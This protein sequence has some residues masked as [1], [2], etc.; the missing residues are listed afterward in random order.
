MLPTEHGSSLHSVGPKQTRVSLLEHLA[1]GDAAAW[2]EVDS[3]YRPMIAAWLSRF[4]LQPSDAEDLSQEV[5]SVLFKR[6][7]TFEH[8]GRTGAFRTWLRTITCNQA[9]SFL[10]SRARRPVAGSA[11][12]AEV[13]DR[14]QQPDSDVAR[15]FDLE[16]DRH[17][18]GYLLKLISPEIAETTMAAFQRHVIDGRDAETVGHELGISPTT[19]IVAKSRVLR[20]LRERAT[21]LVGETALGRTGEADV[22]SGP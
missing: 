5:M 18:L 12:L 6:L 16:H 9:R 13:V 11:R 3:I 21:M 10:R 15:S 8:N 17:L 4:D 19:V 14:L 7:S 22:E 1:D 20:R 2:A